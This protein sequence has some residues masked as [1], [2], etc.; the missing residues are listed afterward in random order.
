MLL[1]AALL[2]RFPQFGN[3]IAGLDEQFY[4]LVGERMH[5]GALPYVDLWDR[6]PI[7]LFL[8]F[9]GIAA[10]PGDGV[11][12]AQLV[13]TLCATGTALLI[14]LI[15]RRWTGWVPAAMAGLFYLGGLNELWGETTQTPVFY[16]LPL[17]AA[18]LL[19]LRAGADPAGPVHRREA[20]AAMLL[21]GLAIQIKTSAVFEGAFFGGWLA[22][23][24]WQTTRS[25]PLTARTAAGF[26]L[27]GAAPTLAAMLG[28]WA[29][30]HFDAWWQANVLSVL[31]KGAPQDAHAIE[32][33][34]G[35][36]VLMAPAALIALLGLWA[37]TRRFTAW[38]TET[39]FLLGW[40]AVSIADFLAIGGYFPHYAMPLLLACCPLLAQG[41]AVRRIGPVLF[42]VTM[43]WPIV[44]ALV[45][46]TRIGA[47]ERAYAAQVVA[48]LPA[49][50]RTQ[51]MFIYEGPV[52]YYHLTDACLV[53]RFAFTA[54]LSS[55]RESHALG[56]D[57]AAALRA[58]IARRPGTVLTIENSTWTDRNPAMER[59]LA[60]L[61]AGRYRP[62]ARLPHRH[63]STDEHILV[64]RRDDLAAPLPRT[65]G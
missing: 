54:H 45:F 20:L 51:C 8:I 32:L 53:T 40:A 33:L 59:E 24:C 43:V 49:D 6:K 2:L 48:A 57:P 15:A 38:P 36:I 63:Y 31:A 21:A 23:R 25:A 60:G 42:A 62:V 29:L 17:A 4:L 11:L 1:A 18:A 28:Y 52:A 10:L 65:G 61:L 56:V 27:A 41:F 16:N 7:G 47:V 34:K 12:A 13:A 37:R 64:W 9:A 5:H 35:S 22:W 30:G 39:F 55:A 46:T 19:T 26:A 58:A 44:H 3:A 50:V 14:V